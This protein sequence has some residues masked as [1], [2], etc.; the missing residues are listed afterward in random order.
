MAKFLVG[1]VLIG[2]LVIT[3][4]AKAAVSFPE[5]ATGEDLP[6]ITGPAIVLA[7]GEE[8]KE[9]EGPVPAEAPPPVVAGLGDKVGMCET[10]EEVLR[11]LAKERSLLEEQRE[12]M[13]LREA[14]LTLAKEKLGIEKAALTELKGSIEDLLARVEAQQ[15]EDLDRL[16]SFYKNMKPAEAAG[17]MDEMDIEVTIM[18]LGTMNPRTAA[19]ILAKMTPVRARA[20]SKI[21]LERGQLPGDQDLTG[22]RLN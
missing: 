10:P 3:A 20:V 11:N 19:P 12:A 22:I 2:G 1:K 5:L 18:V 14:E 13:N 9:P 6:A 17:I 15:T 4:F 21:I 16:I 7:A 8:E